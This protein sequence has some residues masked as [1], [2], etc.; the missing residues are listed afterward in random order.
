MS[1]APIKPGDT[2]EHVNT[3]YI[4]EVV[5]RSPSI[6]R[7]RNETGCWNDDARYW[8]TVQCPK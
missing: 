3:G 8:R 4:A 7:V 2:V 1:P 5:N 6:V